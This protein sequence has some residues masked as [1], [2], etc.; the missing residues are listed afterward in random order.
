MVYQTRALVLNQFMYDDNKLIVKMYTEQL[1]TVSYLAYRSKEKR[2]RS[3]IPLSMSLVEV[4]G[5]EKQRGHLHY[6]KEVKLLE[7][8]Q[9]PYFDWAKSSVSLFLNEIL[10]RLLVDIGEDGRLFHFLY[11][12]LSDFMHREFTPDF[13]LRFLV[14]LMQEL[15][16]SPQDNHSETAPIFNLASGRFEPM[17]FEDRE[18]QM[19]SRLFFRLLNQGLFPEKKEEIVPS[20]WRNKL[21]DMILNYYTLHIADFSTIKSHEVLKTVLH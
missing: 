17:R 12:S 13:H 16:F 8:E 19:I 9:I 5:E 1:G 6:I 4:L 2:K 7:I 10:Y 15:G 18:Q 3:Q 14:A 20:S 11:A 21:L